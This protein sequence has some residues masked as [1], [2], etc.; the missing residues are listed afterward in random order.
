MKQAKDVGSFPLPAFY[1]KTVRYATFRGAQSNDKVWID[2]VPFDKNTK[3]ASEMIK[4]LKD[5]ISEGEGVYYNGGK[6]GHFYWNEKGS[7][8]GS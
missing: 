8:L 3:Y 7:L 6:I 2:F 1:P 5:C 4:L